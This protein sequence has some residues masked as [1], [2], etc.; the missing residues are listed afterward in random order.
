MWWTVACKRKKSLT[1]TESR[2]DIE[3]IL[4][5]KLATINEEPEMMISDENGPLIKQQRSVSKK[6]M[7]MKNIHLKVKIGKLFTS[8]LR[9]KGSFV[10]FLKF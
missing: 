1:R 7:I 2:M 9:F 6:V 5:M 3:E 10:Y 4:K 8:Q